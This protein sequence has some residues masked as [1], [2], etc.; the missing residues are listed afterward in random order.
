MRKIYDYGKYTVDQM[1]VCDV[2]LAYGEGRNH[3]ALITDLLRDETG[4]VVYV[5]VSEDVRTSCRRALFTEEEY[6]ERF[7]LFGVYRYDFIEDVPDN[8]PAIDK[9]LFESGLDKKLPDIA[10]DYGNKSNYKTTEDVIT[11]RCILKINTAYGH[12]I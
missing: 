4:K 9:H 3:V 10:V 7:H 8:D 1:E 6:Y 2:L 5:E 11:S 12:T